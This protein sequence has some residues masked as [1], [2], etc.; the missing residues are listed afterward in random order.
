M[1]KIIGIDLGT[2]NS[3]VSVLEGGEPKVIPNAEGNRT[4]PSVVSF[5]NGEV[6][7]GDERAKVAGVVYNRLKNKQKLQMCSTIQYILGEPHAKLYDVDLEIDSPYN[8]YMYIGLPIGP[9]ANPGASA[10]NAALNP[11]VHDYYYFVLMDEAT[12]KHYF[13]KTYAEHVG[14]KSKYID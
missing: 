1:S 13:S 3:C 6:R 11:E 4:T 14:A 7:V 9:I 12:G 8:T 2:T 5:K 10:I